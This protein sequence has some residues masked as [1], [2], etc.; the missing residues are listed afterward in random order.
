MDPQ[1]ILNIII[2]L[3]VFGLALSVWCIGV[4]LWLGRYLVRLKSV[5]SRL[6]IKPKKDRLVRE[7]T[8]AR[9]FLSHFIHRMYDKFDENIAILTLFNSF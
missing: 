8:R 6:G 4:F 9:I 1:K 5:Q 2:S 3:A 7:M